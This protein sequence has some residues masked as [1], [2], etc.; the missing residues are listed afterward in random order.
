MY[1]RAIIG[2]NIS[3][4]IDSERQRLGNPK[5]T[6]HYFDPPTIDEMVAHLDSLIDRDSIKDDSSFAWLRD[7]EP[8]EQS[9][10]DNEM[11]LCQLDYLHWSENYCRI[12]LSSLSDK[13]EGWDELDRDSEQHQSAG[14]GKF[15]LNGMQVSVM[16]KLAALEE[17]SW[18]Q[19]L[20]HAPVNGILLITLKA[21]RLGASTLWQ[22]LLRHRVNFFSNFPALAA[23]IDAQA[24]Q[25]L[26]RRSERMY[27]MMPIWMRA[28]IK[29]QTIDGGTEYRNGSLIELQDFKQQKDLGK[30]EAWFGFHGTEASSIPRADGRDRF[31]DHFDEG[32]FPT[33]PH[34]RRVIFGMESTA[35]G[36]LG[37]WYEFCVSVMSGT[38][39]GGAGRFDWHF[40]P[41][42]LIDAYE[43][44]RG[45]RSRYRI[46]APVDWQ[47]NPNTVLMAERVHETSLDHMPDHQRVRLDRDVM[48]WYEVTRQQYFRK[49]KLNIFK[50]NYPV[51]A[52]DAFQH[53]AAGAF[54]TETIDRLQHNCARYEPVAYRLITSDEIPLVEQYAI[55]PVLHV[56]G[57]HIGPMHPDELDKDPRGIIWLWEQPDSRF[58][59]VVAADPANG[60]PRWSRVFRTT[61]DTTKDNACAQV[62]RKEKSARSCDDC[63]GLGW[64][65]T[66]QKGVQIECSSC[67]GR[68]KL[69][70]QGVQ[71]AEFAAPIDPEDFALIIYIMGRL[72]RGS[73]EMEESRAIVNSKSI[74]V[75]TIRTLQN[76]YL[77]TNL[78]QTETV[79]QGETIKLL[80]RVGFDETPATVPVLHARGRTAI[81]RRDMEPRS[82]WMVRELSDAV[83]RI[84]ADNNRERFEVPSGAG[85]HDD[86]MITGFLG[87]WLLFDW[88]E[89]SDITEP[90]SESLAR[91]LPPSR[92]LAAS[93]ATAADQHR[94]WNEAAEVLFEGYDLHFGHYP[95]CAV[96]CKADHATEDEIAEYEKDPYS[97][98]AESEVF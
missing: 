97:D 52:V 44:A 38:A 23:S 48:Y 85:R 92:N 35:K 90:T 66:P 84:Y 37:G 40:S 93:D 26:N 67:M 39:E 13:P 70:G 3:R 43:S 1:S 60:I 63:A 5:F 56:G 50:Q 10:I 32:L 24:T 83:V 78:Y 29:R 20:R 33:I 9:F 49:G 59:Y 80:N 34:D 31:E 71:V 88:T 75:L 51:E 7:L 11:A 91:E 74:G 98:E 82:K 57:Y 21:R 72:Y 47:P 76:K 28:K 4:Y 30:Q 42:Y 95:D 16:E 14:Y 6:L 58:E 2:R 94:I 19:Y 55:A 27:T 18:D 41:F 36:K 68:G 54:T 79:A 53:S 22:A 46:E 17:R 96:S 81:V 45:Q 87:G 8:A 86:R 62:W 65:P 61:D 69:G 12:E 89:L 25:S 73:A 77:Y 15:I 64:K